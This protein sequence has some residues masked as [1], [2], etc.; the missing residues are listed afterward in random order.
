MNFLKWKLSVATDCTCTVSVYHS[1]ALVS[2]ILYTFYIGSLLNNHL[3]KAT[4]LEN[5][6]TLV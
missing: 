4:T 2:A 5:K 6:T 1:S 3:Y